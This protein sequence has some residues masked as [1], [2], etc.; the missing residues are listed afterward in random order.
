MTARDSRPFYL[1]LIKIRLPI[2]GVVSIIHR[3]TGVLMFLAIPF[4]V[5]LLDLSLQGEAGFT[6]ASEILS[7]TIIRLGMLLLLWSLLHHF[8]AGIRYLLIDFDIAVDKQG[9]RKTAWTVLVLEIITL[10]ILVAGICS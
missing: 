4:F 3:V 6:R 2:Q 7:L 5:Y 10:V 9:S 1:N 8:Y